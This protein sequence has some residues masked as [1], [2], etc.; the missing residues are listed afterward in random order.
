MYILVFLICIS[1]VSASVFN[2][3]LKKNSKELV[4]CG[5][6][7]CATPSDFWS[8]LGND[9]CQDKWF[10]IAVPVLRMGSSASCG[11]VTNTNISQDIK[12]KA[13]KNYNVTL[14]IAGIGAKGENMTIYISDNFTIFKDPIGVGNTIKSFIAK[15]TIDGNLTINGQMPEVT[16]TINRLNSISVKEVKDKVFRWK[17]KR[18]N[19]DKVFRWK[20]KR[21]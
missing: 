4:T 14:D 6:F 20:L 2:L 13:G 7:D 10:I 18:K 8:N 12:F 3:K 17:P 9:F 1:L 19:T 16:R 11:F 21:K 5:N 15:P